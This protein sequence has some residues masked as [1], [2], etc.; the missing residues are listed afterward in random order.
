MKKGLR[1]AAGRS[2]LA[3]RG[4]TPLNVIPDEEG[5]ET[6]APD[7]TTATVTRLNVIPD[8][9]GIE[10]APDLVAV[11]RKMVLNVIPDEEGIETISGSP[12]APDDLER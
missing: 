4:S 2:S 6:T 12:R 1:P 5:I 3:G 8:E 9:E 11:S 7:E 10:T